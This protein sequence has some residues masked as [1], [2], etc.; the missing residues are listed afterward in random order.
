[1]PL[2]K[3]FTTVTP[4]SK[5]LALILVIVLPFAGFYVGMQAQKQMSLETLPA[6]QLPKMQNLPMPSS[7]PYVGSLP[8]E[9]T[10][11]N[12]A[13]HITFK[14]P[15]DWKIQGAGVEGDPSF[16]GLVGFS[17]L[18]GSSPD[19]QGNDVI[20]ITY[21]DNPKKLSIKQFDEE[22]KM[23]QEEPGK[24]LYVASAKPLTI[25][26]VRGYYNQGQ[27]CEPFDCDK[28]VVAYGDKIFVIDRLVSPTDSVVTNTN[29]RKALDLILSTFKFVS[30]NQTIDTAN[31]KTHAYAQFGY[32]IKLPED[33][34]I[35]ENTNVFPPDPAILQLINSGSG[36][37]AG[38][39]GPDDVIIAVQSKNLTQ[40]VKDLGQG[41]TVQK[42]KKVIN[43][44]SWTV[45]QTILNE[46]IYLTQL[47]QKT[48]SVDSRN[49]PLLDK[50]VST[51][52]LLK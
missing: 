31:W 38:N 22:G 44:I 3:S 24:G 47:G 25:G 29:S 18:G 30:Q 7:T 40:S 46:R 2:P 52:K 35:I 27:G 9:Q 5:T 32:S 14:F 16:H 10:Y 13:L 20:G 50:V 1:M 36:A 12:A 17:P 19:F 21:W 33:Y 45:V 43:N 8:T 42:E 6:A 15:I 49:F 28:Y 23:Y 4:L 37:G 41:V 48:Y 39:G 51:F 34:Q 26:G 11:T